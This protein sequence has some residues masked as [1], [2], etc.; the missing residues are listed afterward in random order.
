[1]L[2]ANALS[3]IRVAV[4]GVTGIIC[5]V[6]ASLALLTGRPD[7]IP[8]W[9]PALF[10]V[11]SAAIIMIAFFS[12]TRRAADMASDEGFAAD[13]GRAH[14]IG[15]LVALFLYPA[16]AA[17]L[18]LGWISWPVAYAAMGTL[19]AAAFLLP[20]VLFDLKGRL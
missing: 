19:T 15:Y 11:G 3:N 8:P 7:P 13:N 4:L 9:V 16:F 18:A 1:M 12:A 10:G 20:F 17:P 2:S 5:L 6:Y 14:K